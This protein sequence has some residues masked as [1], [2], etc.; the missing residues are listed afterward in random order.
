MAR[1]INLALALVLAILVLTCRRAVASAPSPFSASAERCFDSLVTLSQPSYSHADKLLRM[2]EASSTFACAEDPALDK[3]EGG[4]RA[5]VASKVFNTTLCQSGLVPAS[6][7][8]AG[9]AAAESVARIPDW[10]RIPI[11]LYEALL[12]AKTNPQALNVSRGERSCVGISFS[13]HS[14]PET[15]AQAFREVRHGRRLLH[16]PDVCG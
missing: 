2:M 8:A 3:V 1:S 15:D 7:C 11:V 10:A 13:L 4:I 9:A 16:V 12:S 14:P 5:V 6:F